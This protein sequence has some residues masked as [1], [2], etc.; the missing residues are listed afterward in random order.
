MPISRVRSVTLASMM[1]VI[2]NAANEQ[3]DTGNRTQYQIPDAFLFFGGRSEFQWNR[4]AD[5]HF[6]GMRG[7]EDLASHG[8][9]LADDSRVPDLQCNLVKLSFFHAERSAA[10]LR[11]EFAESALCAGQR[12]LISSFAPSPPEAVRTGTQHP[13]D[14]IHVLSQEYRL[15]DGILELKKS[16]GCTGRKDGHIPRIAV[17]H[18]ADK[19]PPTIPTFL[20]CNNSGVVPRIV[21]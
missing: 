17:V 19:A 14:P 16:I 3:R 9:G 15:S 5:V 21:R 1:F 18:S 11:L 7:Q 2:D 8:S 4:Q 13:D 12:E 6:F 10:P 20:T